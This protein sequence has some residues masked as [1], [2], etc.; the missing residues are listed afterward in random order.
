MGNGRNL[1]RILVGKPKGKINLED[2][3]VDGRT[4]SKWSLGRLVAGVWNGLTWLRI[5]IIGGLL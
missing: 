3:G 1:Y 4:G 2:Q 5:G